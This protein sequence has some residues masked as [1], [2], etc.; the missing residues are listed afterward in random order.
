MD[1]WFKGVAL[2][3]AV[4]MFALSGCSGT[5]HTVR[6][7]FSHDS[8]ETDADSD[9]SGWT[10]GAS[11]G[12]IARDGIEAIET[13]GMGAIHFGSTELNLTDNKIQTGVSTVPFSACSEYP[14][15]G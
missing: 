15:N 6:V 10:A 7:G 1:T 11:L 12:I 3:L 2:A 9:I 4:A 5:K 13:C 14:V 8:L